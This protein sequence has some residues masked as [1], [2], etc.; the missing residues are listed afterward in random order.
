MYYIKGGI[1][2]H[3]ADHVESN[4]I[5]HDFHLDFTLVKFE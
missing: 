4:F 3:E 2:K 1:N 5:F